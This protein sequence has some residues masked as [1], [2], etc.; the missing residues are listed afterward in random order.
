[1][2][3][4]RG[5][6]VRRPM[7]Y[8]ASY[9]ADPSPEWSGRTSLA[10]EWIDRGPP[11]GKSVYELTNDPTIAAL[12]AVTSAA[13]VRNV[14][15]GALHRVLASLAATRGPMAWESLPLESLA[16]VAIPP[17]IQSCWVF[18]IRP[19][20]ATGAERH[21]NSHQRSLSLC[22][23]GRFELHDGMGWRAFPLESHEVGLLTGRWVTIPPSTWHR[24]YAGESPWGMLSFHTVHA[25]QLLEE[26][27]IT[28]GTL[29]GPTS[30]RPYLG[31][32]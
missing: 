20:E 27:P 12:D 21:P 25:E 18:V 17:A 3:Q 7:A 32:D 22:G 30:S 13:S 5:I 31:G 1:M 10:R 24:L 19:G 28:E 8:R 29:A 9:A 14:I 2:V 16:A 23:S 11:H 26:R 15:R 4:V 6:T